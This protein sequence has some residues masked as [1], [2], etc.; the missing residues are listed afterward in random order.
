MIDKIALTP[1][2]AQS[3]DPWEV[4]KLFGVH[5]T[6]DINPFDHSGFFYRS[7]EWDSYDYAS[8]IG[9]STDDSHTWLESGC[10]NKRGDEKE[11]IRRD[12]SHEDEETLLKMEANIH[13][14]IEAA[15]YNWG[16]ENEPIKTYTEEDAYRG[17]EL[18]AWTTIL[19]QLQAWSEEMDQE[20][21]S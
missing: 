17:C 20:V 9:F 21:E 16:N 7:D 10:V 13:C 3:A 15:F 18:E 19:E 5:F 1:E 14:Q 11:I 6:G 12:F 4:A 2:Q 8:T